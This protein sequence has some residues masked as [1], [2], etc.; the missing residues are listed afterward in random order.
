MVFRSACR[1]HRF[2]CRGGGRD[3]ARAS[4]ET[5]VPHRTRN[6]SGHIENAA[7]NFLRFSERLKERGADDAFAL[8]ASIQPIGVLG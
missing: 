7:P 2:C 3:Y 4:P 1:G 6:F 8:S 5:I